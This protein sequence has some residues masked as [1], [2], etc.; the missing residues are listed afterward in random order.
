[1]LTPRVRETILS[2]SSLFMPCSVLRSAL[3]L[4]LAIT[5]LSFRRRR[6][7]R[8]TSF[9]QD[10]QTFEDTLPD[11]QILFLMV[12]ERVLYHLNFAG[13]AHQQRVRFLRLRSEEHTSELQ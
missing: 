8:P 1:M 4:P 9:F 12:S 3:P 2:C 7:V 6:L 5:N 10:G 13:L 11:Y